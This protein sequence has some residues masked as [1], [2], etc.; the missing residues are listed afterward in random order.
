MGQKPLRA[1]KAAKRPPLISVWLALLAVAIQ[2]LLIQPHI[3]GLPSI[4]AD[5]TSVSA[6]HASQTA[7][8]SNPAGACVVCQAM[9]TAG[10]FAL[11]D[12]PSLLLLASTLFTA[13]AASGHVNPE[14]PVS[15]DWQ[16]RGPPAAI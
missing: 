5:T 13:P 1:A 10:A 4:S 3:D 12:A 16:S 8:A 11:A 14:R 2:C 7:P 9:A 15:H 6:T